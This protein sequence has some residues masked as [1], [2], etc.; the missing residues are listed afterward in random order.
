MVGSHLIEHYFAKGIKPVATY[1]SPTIDI[2]EV[3]DKC[4]Y[5]Y[6]D[7]TD[8]AMTDVL[9]RESM[10]DI[11]YHLA[12]QSLPVLSWQLPNETMHTNSAGTVNVFESV[13][14]L[15]ASHPGYD[16]MIVVAC[17]S[18][19]YGATLALYD[20]PVTEDAALLPLHPYGVSKVAQDLLAFQYFSTFGIRCIRARIFNTTG[21]RKQNDVVSDF[22][23]RAVQIELGQAT[24]FNCGNLHTRRAITDV[25]DLIV[26][27]ELLAEK[28]MPG[29]VYNISGAHI[30]EMQD[31]VTTI[32]AVMD[33]RL[34][35]R[36]DP[37]LMRPQDEP[38]IYG[39]SSKL[40]AATGWQQT[41][42]LR[43]TIEDMIAYW[44][45]KLQK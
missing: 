43:Q 31:I 8:A 15:K 25:R 23:K 27:L 24:D 33:C 32:E 28:G 1:F 13:K 3:A 34:N 37:A 30:Y 19:E 2:T 14:K 39:D 21:V 17:S 20:G 9:I 10:P 40:H 36:Q 22:T 11:I 42:P 18:A 4:A 29:D 41:I 7:V 12:A 38:I 44:R 35:P 5:R 6:C 16:P 45:W 26:A